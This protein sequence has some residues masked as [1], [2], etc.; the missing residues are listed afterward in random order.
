VFV[1][2]ITA[3][4]VFVGIGYHA[5]HAVSLTLTFSGNYHND[6]DTVF[7]VNGAGPIPFSYTLTYDTALDT[8]TAFFATGA[9]LGSQTTTHEWYGYSASGIT[10]ASVT[11]GTKTWNITA[12]SP[13]IPASGVSADFWL[14][15]DISLATPS[16]AWILFSDGSGFL[17]L[18]G[19]MGS[20]TN[21]VMM[22]G[23]A[24][25][26]AGSFDDFRT[27]ALTI[28]RDEIQSLPEP[29]TWKLLGTGL[30]GLAFYGWR[31]KK[32][33]A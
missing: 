23:S 20:A 15:T 9:S 8:N 27:S 5:A 12:I 7:G 19:G 31:K 25:M 4:L 30:V 10:A 21:I 33:T 16:M 13:R 28:T 29:S 32:Q 2:A 14:D 18:G 26:E 3:A 24:V 11:F 17:E 6:P 1:I 22:S